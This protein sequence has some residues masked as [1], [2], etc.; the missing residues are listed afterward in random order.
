[1]A[2]KS[3]DP[4]SAGYRES[5]QR[6]RV[7]GDA[8]AATSNEYVPAQPTYA[9]PLTAPPPFFISMPFSR[10]PSPSNCSDAVASE[11]RLVVGDAARDRHAAEPVRAS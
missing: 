2:V 4:N 6:Q 7:D 11:E 5:G 1:V 9:A 8:V 3:S 10:T